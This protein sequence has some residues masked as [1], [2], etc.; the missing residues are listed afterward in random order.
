MYTTYDVNL[1]DSAEE[2]TIRISEDGDGT[3]MVVCKA[4]TGY[5]GKLDFTMSTDDA[6]TFARGILKQIQF[7]KENSQ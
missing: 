4:D 3:G 1:F 5:F 7:I 2:T 6:E